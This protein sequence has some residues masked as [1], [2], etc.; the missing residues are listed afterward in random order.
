M[1]KVGING[2]G[3]IGRLALRQYVIDPPENIDIVAINDLIPVDELA[4]L[5]K[6]DSI[7]GKAPFHIEAGPDYL[8]LDEK[9]IYVTSIPDPSKIPWSERDVKVVL[10]CTGRFT[11]REKAKGHLEGGATKVIISAPS[12]SADISIVMGVNE[13]EYDPLKHSIISN[14]SCTTNSMAP[15]LK[16]LNE[17]LGIVYVMATT[18]H[19]YTSS[20]T[21]VDS[22]LSKRRR[23]R[24]GAFS[25]IPTSTGAAKATAL[26]LPELKGKLDAIAVRVP[27]PDGALTDM[28]VHFES[29]VSV[30]EINNILKRAS[31]EELRNIIEYNDEEIV[32][33]DILGNPHSG[34]VDGPSTRVLQN[35]VAKILVWYDNE[36]GYSRRMI[37]VANFISR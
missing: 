1:K 20:Q 9:R 10:E 15:V 7:H 36:Y 35:R 27:I 32:S 11:K 3:R 13:K 26:V 14:A 29:D 28:V 8:D 17:S 12:E 37:D 21:L 4:Y 23:G 2:L 33:A 24:A 16:V 31:E 18:V 25:L 30:A 19:A 22:P 5:L 34:V 6:Y